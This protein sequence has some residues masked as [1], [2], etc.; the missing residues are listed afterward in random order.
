MSGCGFEHDD[1]AYVLGAL[2]SEDRTAFERHLSSCESCSRSVRELAGLPGLLARVPVEILDPEELPEPVPDTLLPGLVR[3]VRRTQR[4]RTW[5]T[6]GLVAAAAVV[7]IGAAGVAT[8]GGDDDGGSPRASVTAS[9]AAMQP[10]GHVPITASVALTPVG[11]GTRVDFTCEYDDDAGTDG[12]AYRDE[13]Q[14]SYAMYVRTT[15]G[16]EEQIASWRALPHKVLR[17]A[18]ATAAERDEITEVEVRSS[19]GRTVLRLAA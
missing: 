13:S 15:T 2:S 3:R 11:W 14:P 12:P 8:L 17:I 1:G 6:T 19:T 18:A 9:A 10:V 4:R 5:L 7:A 16:A